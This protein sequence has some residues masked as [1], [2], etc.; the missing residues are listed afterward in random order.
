MPCLS[1]RGGVDGK[2]AVADMLVQGSGVR[3]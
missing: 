3:V 1:R 2:R